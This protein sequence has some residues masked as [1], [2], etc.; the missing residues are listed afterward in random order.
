[1]R[2]QQ[3]EPLAASVTRLAAYLADQEEAGDEQCVENR[4]ECDLH[5]VEVAQRLGLVG[6]VVQAEQLDRLVE[7]VV[8]RE[9]HEEALQ[10]HRV[11]LHHAPRP[12]EVQHREH[13]PELR[14]GE[15]ARQRLTV[16]NAK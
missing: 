13:G 15:R 5:D 11:L 1:M 12:K 7:H 9:D 2:R 16:M 10:A 4:R 14:R 6:A 8:Q 3:R